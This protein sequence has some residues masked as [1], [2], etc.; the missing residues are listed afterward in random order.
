MLS[1]S[2]LAS[3]PSAAVEIYRYVDSNGRVHLTDRPPHDGYQLIQKA[4][5]KLRI[6]RINFRD[7]DANRKRFA[8]KITEVASRYQV[9]EALIHAIIAI[10]SA[11]DPNAISR[12]GAVGLMQ[13][14]PA[15]AKRY[16]VADRRDPSANLTGGTRYLKDLLLRFDSNLEL[17]IAGYNAGENAVEKFGNRV[18]PFDETRSYVR[19]VL[20]LYSQQFAEPF[21]GA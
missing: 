5:E 13:L 1:I 17:T 8:S 21:G 7:K 18:P 20:E 4:G 2:G 16:G 14:M 12:A 11:Y 10:E 3:G 9:P 15:T 19:K 6:P